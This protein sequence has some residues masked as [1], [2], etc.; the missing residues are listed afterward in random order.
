M[1]KDKQQ[2][3]RTDGS[4]RLIG[5]RAVLEGSALGGGA[6]A[7]GF[8]GPLAGTV[9][10]GQVPGAVQPVKT[11]RIRRVA[12][13]Q[14]S[15]GK[16][17]IAVDEVVAI[18]DVWATTSEQPLG[19]A[20]DGEHREDF[21]RATGDT[22]CFI[23]ALPPSQDPKP[24]LTNRIGFHRTNG[25]AYCYVLNGEVVF[26]ADEEEVRLQAGDLLIE[27]GT[28]H[29]WR[30]EGTEPVGLMIVVAPAT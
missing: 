13:G 11:G 3:R 9:V 19:P 26:L 27:R 7:A 2:G 17:Y 16:S 6:L 18:N 20:P 22:S 8:F 1:S 12:T 28:D 30:N 4:P 14:N 21:S 25:V 23:S 10:A 29:S 24:N 5:R 15:A